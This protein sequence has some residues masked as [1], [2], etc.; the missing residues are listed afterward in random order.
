VPRRVRAATRVAPKSTTGATYEALLDR[1]LRKALLPGTLL[2]ERRLAEA[3]GV[4]RTP[5]REA[6]S[7][8]EGEGLVVRQPGRALMVKPI[9]I[10]DYLDAL[11]VRRLLEPEAAARS[12]G[13]LPAAET[14]V[15]REQ[16]QMLLA[17]PTPSPA[18]HWAVDDAVHEAIAAAGGSDLMAG[19]IRNLRRRTRIFNLTRMP[20]RFAPGCHEHLAILNAIAA[21]DAAGAREAMSAHLAN[22]KTSII[23]KLTER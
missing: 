2:Q 5:L 13:R 4:S 3:L 17:D 15:L 8:L 18:R 20:D 11:D 16:I 22:V 7:R 23:Q 1:I 10:N 19:I 12:I 14:D 21:G 6:L 9:T